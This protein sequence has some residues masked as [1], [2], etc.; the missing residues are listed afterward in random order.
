LISLNKNGA[1]AGNGPKVVFDPLAHPNP[2]IPL[3]NDLV[4]VMDN[5][6]PTG[7]K[8]NIRHNAATR[9]ERD[10]RE[11]I[12]RLELSAQACH[13]RGMQL[14]GWIRVQNHGESWGRN[15]MDRFYVEHQHLLEKNIN[16]ETD[17][18]LC[19]AYPEVVDFHVKVVEIGKEGT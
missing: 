4:T 3:P 1:D 5:N 11:E 14:F 7:L 19:L 15:P 17:T 6:S 18:R 10:N 13:E 12:N 2:E 8:V 16:G 9:F